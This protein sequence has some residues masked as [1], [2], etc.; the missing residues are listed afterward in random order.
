MYQVFS[1]SC[2]TQSYKLQQKLLNQFIENRNLTSGL[3]SSKKER[4]P[5]KFLRIF[6]WVTGRPVNHVKCIQSLWIN[7]MQS[8]KLLAWSTGNKNCILKF[9]LWL[10][11]IDSQINS[12]KCKSPCSYYYCSPLQ[13][14]FWLKQRISVSFKRSF[15]FYYKSV[16]SK[17]ECHFYS[18]T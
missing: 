14:I 15:Q 11:S 5:E 18:M 4:F 7:K 16:R 8:V 6:F 9:K 1:I 3:I 10:I 12:N 2:C 13:F 17:V